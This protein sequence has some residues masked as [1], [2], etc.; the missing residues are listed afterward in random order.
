MNLKRWHKCDVARINKIL[1]EIYNIK[2]K[3]IENIGGKKNIVCKVTMENKEFVIK[4]YKVGDMKQELKLLQICTTLSITV[5][6]VEHVGT[7]Y[8]ILEYINGINMGDL[9]ENN[10]SEIHI[11]KLSQ[12]IFEFHTKLKNQMGIDWIKGD[13]RITNYIFS[14]NR[15]Y[16]IDFEESNNGPWQ[17]DIAEIATSILD[18]DPMFTDTKIK[19][20]REFIKQYLIL[21]KNISKKEIEVLQKFII[22]TLQDTSKRRGNIVEINNFVEQIKQDKIKLI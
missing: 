8:I 10:F 22:N 4:I 18:L 19:I 14:N 16:G 21:R 12:W 15:V 1:Y 9:L 2:A 11:K 7:D 6:K 5:P 20:A 3:S 17:K 13:S